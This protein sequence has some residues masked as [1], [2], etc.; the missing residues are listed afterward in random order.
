MF[1]AELDNC[2]QALSL[3]I[4]VDKVVLAKQLREDAEA[5]LSLKIRLLV[6]ER[7]DA[8]VVERVRLEGMSVLSELKKV[9]ENFD[10]FQAELKKKLADF[11]EQEK[12]SKLKVLIGSDVKWSPD[13]GFLG[14]GSFGKVYKGKY[15]NLP[16]AVKVLTVPK[17]GLKP[18]DIASLKEECRIVQ[19]LDHPLIIGFFGGIYDEAPY[20]LVM[21]R[22]M[23]SLFD[24]IH[25]PISTL[26]HNGLL[27]PPEHYL[28]PECV[29]GS[30]KRFVFTLAFKLAL[31]EDVAM[32]VEY[33]HSLN[34]L[35][36]YHPPN[37]H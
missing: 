30:T 2:C 34:I 27:L 12:S 16:V 18:D 22:G 26:R 4:L 9:A 35:H 32:A 11:R 25:T 5:D 7:V 24:L 14:E 3:D 13:E 21:E 10:S 6:S 31:L 29:A 1:N 37:Y 33:L 8:S 17:S 36:R 15:N 20:C 23:C 19:C 28:T